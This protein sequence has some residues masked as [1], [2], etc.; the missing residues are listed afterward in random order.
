MYKLYLSKYNNLSFQFLL[1][2]N[3][4]L[5]FDSINCFL[6]NVYIIGVDENGCILLKYK[7]G[8]MATLSYHTSAVM[9]DNDAV[10]YGDKDQLKVNNIVFFF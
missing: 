6:C 2:N 3:S 1:E 10:I 7:D 9:A 4:A 8:A 5:C